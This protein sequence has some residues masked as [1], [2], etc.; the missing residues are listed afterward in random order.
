MSPQYRAAG[1]PVQIG[2]SSIQRSHR[3]L[4]YRRA[5]GLS[6]SVISAVFRLDAHG[7]SRIWPT[8]AVREFTSSTL[9]PLSV[10]ITPVRSSSPGSSTAPS[11]ASS[12]GRVWKQRAAAADPRAPVFFL[13]LR[14]LAGASAVGDHQPDRNAGALQEVATA[15]ADVR[16]ALDR[17]RGGRVRHR[18]RRAPAPVG[19]ESR[20]LDRP[21]SDG[22][23]PL[24]GRHVK[25]NRR[26]KI[27]QRRAESKSRGGVATIFAPAGAR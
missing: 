5:F 7:T 14:D 8:S 25:L 2:W 17:R 19:V 11:P 22:R 20:R 13:D 10:P 27:A 3:L 26:S 23:S 21:G 24:T 9:G 18:I 1:V 12:S 4:F 15:V 6:A 16:P